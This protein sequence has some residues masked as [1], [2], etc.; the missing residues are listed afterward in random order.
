MRHGMPPGCRNLRCR[1]EGGTLGFGVTCKQRVTFR[2]T[3]L[4]EIGL[5]GGGGGHSTCVY[6]CLSIRMFACVC[7]CE[8]IHTYI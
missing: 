4:H 7:V 6:A 2:H 5:G 3:A 8:C 1:R